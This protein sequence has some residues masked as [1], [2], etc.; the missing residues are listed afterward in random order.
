MLISKNERYSAA[1][2]ITGYESVTVYYAS[3]LSAKICV[4]KDAAVWTA[5]PEGDAL[6]IA[7][8]TPI[9][10][11]AS[12]LEY[13][14]FRLQVDAAADDR[15]ITVTKAN[16][17]DA[18]SASVAYKEGAIVSYMGT[19]YQAIADNTNQN[20]TAAWT[21]WVRQDRGASLPNFHYCYKAE[22]NR[23]H[24]MVTVGVP[25]GVELDPVRSNGITNVSAI[26][27]TIT[28]F[29][30]YGATVTGAVLVT[31]S[32]AHGLVTGQVVIIDST[33]N[34]NGVYLITKVA[35]DT[36]YVTATWVADDAT[37][38]VQ[39]PETLLIPATGAGHYVVNFGVTVDAAT[40]DK[41]VAIG[42]YQNATLVAKASAHLA[43]TEP[44]NISSAAWV[45]AVA[46]DVLWMGTIP[47]TD[48]TDVVV[49]EHSLVIAQQ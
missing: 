14:F 19:A 40:A 8:A 17:F 47:V 32:S 31:T 35:A 24:A 42:L 33:T 43:D 21:Y 29:A 12:A 27:A 15:T 13:N 20:P 41:S 6:E 16:R 34:Y 45:L 22:T 30:D 7:A 25:V 18:W 44:Q 39:K 37:G 5:L 48:G 10:L 3:A 2:Q 4:S 26:T 46:G 1:E 38:T 23:T 9:A 36:F 28:H 49:T 11:P